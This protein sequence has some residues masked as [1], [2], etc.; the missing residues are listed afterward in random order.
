MSSSELACSYTN[1]GFPLTISRAARKTAICI[2]PVS[3]R[4]SHRC[5]TEIYFHTM[6]EAMIKATLSFPIGGGSGGPSCFSDATTSEESDGDEVS[7]GFP[8]FSASR[9]VDASWGIV[10]APMPASAACSKLG[11]SCG[12]VS[13]AM[14]A[15]MG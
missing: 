14:F 13:L 5:Y 8:P 10:S 11:G 7:A 2:Q 1:I 3:F 6:S 4:P 15:N 12:W 9:F